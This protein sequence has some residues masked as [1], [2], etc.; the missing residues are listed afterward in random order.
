MKITPV[1]YAKTLYGSTEGKSKSEI[2]GIASS[3]VKVLAKNNHLK[4]AQK[5]IK[6]FSDIY[7]KENN[8]I[9][10]E[11]ASKE[12]LSNELRNKV[13]KYI[14]NKYKA[15]K[16]VLNNKIDENIKGG[17]VIR[18][19]DEVVDASVAKKLI[20]LKNNLSK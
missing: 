10:A 5:I 20:D 12:K 6:N 14:S 7:N 18:V 2:D 11:V 4:L 15:K 9:E 3:F 8:I 16:V 1:Q 19:G 17:I 13:G